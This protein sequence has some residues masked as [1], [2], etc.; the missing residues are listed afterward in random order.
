MRTALDFEI[1]RAWFYFFQ[2]QFF[3]R[4]GEGQRRQY[5]V[6][7]IASFLRELST[8]PAADVH[9]RY[10]IPTAAKN[11]RPR[12]KRQPH[13]PLPFTCGKVVLYPAKRQSIRL[14]YMVFNRPK[15]SRSD[16]I[17]MLYKCLLVYD[18]HLAGLSDYA[19]AKRMI[20]DAVTYRSL[21]SYRNL[22]PWYDELYSQCLGK[23]ELRE[24]HNTDSTP[25]SVYD[26][27]R[28]ISTNLLPEQQDDSQ[29]RI[30]QHNPYRSRTCDIRRYRAIAEKLLTITAQGNFKNYPSVIRSC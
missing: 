12:G 9:R 24:I 2:Y 29:G 4:S 1:Y 6:S 27:Q 13:E 23:F 22:G 16:D 18:L 3:I 8:G 17:T 20:A 30:E 7:R 10:E 28:V 15:H 11:K 5:P 14:R 26:Y 19:I 25:L 21:S